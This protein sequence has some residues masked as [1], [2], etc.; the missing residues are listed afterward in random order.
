MAPNMARHSLTSTS[1][2]PLSKVLCLLHSAAMPQLTLFGTLTSPYVR[3]VRI[4]L[5][6]LGVEATWVDT[7][8]D[9]GQAELRASNPLWKIPALSLDGQLVLDSAVINRVL[10]KQLGP[11]PLAPYDESELDAVNL[12]TII[13]GALDALINTMY[14]GKDGITPAKAPYL[15]KHLDRAA[16]SMKWLDARIQGPL[17]TKAQ[18]FGLPEI[19]LVTTAQWARFRN[20]YDIDQH[21]NIAA[22]V[23]EHLKRPSVRDT[24]PPQ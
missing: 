7:T 6:E 12:V 4:V 15:Q 24:E 3:R 18:N 16:A 23:A 2:E 13:D 5:R 20:M 22:C 17:L 9:A 10:L 14:L 1:C 19:A 11:G 21:S 8:T